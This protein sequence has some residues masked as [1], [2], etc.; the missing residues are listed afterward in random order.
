MTTKWTNTL[1]AFTLL[2]ALCSDASAFAQMDRP[3]IP[4]EA[5]RHPQMLGSFAQSAATLVFRTGQC[6]AQSEFTFSIGSASAEASLDWGHCADS[7]GHAVRVPP[8]RP[9]MDRV[10]LGGNP[11]D[12]WGWCWLIKRMCLA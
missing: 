1:F 5:F 9:G 8:A 3:D 12:I 4:S 10:A 7:V 2:L 11:H 6:F